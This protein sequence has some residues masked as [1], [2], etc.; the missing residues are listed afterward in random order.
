M[1]SR[2]ARGGQDGKKEVGACRCPTAAGLPWF[3]RMMTP[4]TAPPADRGKL[5]PAG[6]IVAAFAVVYLGYGLNFLAVKVAVET[7]PAFLFAGSHVLLAGLLIMAWRRAR[8]GSLVLPEG[9]MAKAA[10]A[11]FFLFVGGVGFVTLGEK[12]GLASGAAAMIKASV[13]LWVAVLEALRP[14]GEKPTWMIGGGL[15]LG[16]LGVLL[17][18]LPNI[19]RGGAGGETLGTWVLLAS[20]LLFAIGTLLV[21]HHPPSGDTTANVAWMMVLGGAYLWVAGLATG[22]AAGIGREDFTGSVLAAFLFLLIV[23]SLGAFSAMNWLLRH[24]PA[25]VVTTKFYVSPAI[26]AVAGWLVLGESIGTGAIVG[27]ALILGGVAV[28]MAGEKRRQMEPALKADD[29]DEL[30]E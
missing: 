10:S 2:S 27:L 26:A 19:A 29:A 25:A 22:E 7:L 9:G 8:G 13:P 11:A 28:V 5:P 15:L 23:H 1:G 6:W 18:V 24:L 14:R 4:I 16:A 30:E 20:A 3:A 12:L 17:L 21:R